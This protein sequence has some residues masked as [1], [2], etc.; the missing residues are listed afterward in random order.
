MKKVKQILNF[1]YLFLFLVLFLATI[2]VLVS[3]TEYSATLYRLAPFIYN[4]TIIDKNSTIDRSIN[5][6]I[7]KLKR[8]LIAHKLRLNRL[9]NL[10]EENRILQSA[11]GLKDSL[12]LNYIPAKVTN[13]T[14]ASYKDRFYARVSEDSLDLIGKPV[15]GLNGVIGVVDSQLGR[16]LVIKM[17][18]RAGFKLSVRT[19]IF[20]YPSLSVSKNE[21]TGYL[22]ELTK[23]REIAVGETVYTST[24]GTLFP[25]DIP[26]GT[27][28]SYFDDDATISKKVEISYIE[29]LL[30]LETVFILEK[31]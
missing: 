4:F 10:R 17:V 16:D 26:V 18:N 12:K 14:K 6:E 30:S 3:N 13:Y 5:S 9:D 21:I 20:R 2:L 27:I 28:K 24:F 1:E 29:N 22:K 25:P 7:I 23:T 11:L 19:Q 15:I 8:E 31:L